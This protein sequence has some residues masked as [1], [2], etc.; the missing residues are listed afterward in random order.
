MHDTSSSLIVNPLH[1]ASTWM[2]ALADLGACGKSWFT[3]Y[4]SNNDVLQSRLKLIRSTVK[5]FLEKFGD[6]PVLI[7][8]TPGRVNLR[9][10]HVDTHGGFLNMMSHQREV[11]FVVA[12]AGEDECDHHFYSLNHAGLVCVPASNYAVLNQCQNWLEFLANKNKATS[13]ANS[14]GA[15]GHYLEGALLRLQMME[16]SNV[17][18]TLCGVVGGDIP[19]GA[20][21]SSSAALCV[22]VMLGAAALN[23]V[24]IDNKTLILAARDAEWYTGARTG[25]GDQSVVVLSNLESILH[26]AIHTDTF[27]PDNFSQIPFPGD[28]SLVVIDSQT[29]RSLSGAQRLA[30]NRNRF[31]YSLAMAA[32]R[33]AATDTGYD[34]ADVA[35]WNRLSMLTPDQLG[36]TSHMVNLLCAIPESIAFDKLA[37]YLPDV[38]V[39]E[40]AQLY[41]EDRLPDKDEPIHLR[42]PLLYALAESERARVF[43]GFLATGQYAMAGKLMGVGHD[44]D[45][46]VAA[47]GSRFISRCDTAF[48]QQHVSLGQPIEMLPG[49]YGA[50]TNVLDSLVDQALLSGALG[51]CLTGAGLAGSV[52]A[53]CL[54]KDADT[55]VSRL[56]EWMSQDDYLRLV[57]LEHQAEGFNINDAVLVNHA[58]AGAS[59]LPF[60]GSDE[61]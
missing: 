53:L 9:G 54:K 41:F 11:V 61:A 37:E 16:P 3:I 23:Q 29:R 20:A 31:A 35:D 55:V 45:R 27:S 39:M 36:S 24:A 13:S 32:L 52:L 40:L 2:H 42:G 21:L 34:R 17:Q 47:D 46:V 38:D 10:M 60:P 15:W 4:G 8:R 58:I 49:V 14:E 6:H 5:T 56:R 30:Y 50:S 59:V 48:L 22:A 51:A 12:V 25:L 43:P 1:K 26:G 18:K 44:G 7:C 57:N 28:L 19:E 33:K